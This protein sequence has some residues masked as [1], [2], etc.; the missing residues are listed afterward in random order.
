MKKILEADLDMDL[1]PLKFNVFFPDT[2]I[3]SPQLDL[4]LTVQYVRILP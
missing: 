2:S 3:V 1:V 4:L